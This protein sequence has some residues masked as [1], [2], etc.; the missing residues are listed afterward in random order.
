MYKA[1]RAGSYRSHSERGIPMIRKAAA[2]KVFPGCHEE[3]RKRHDELWPEM[4]EML[5]QHGMITYSIFLEEATDTLFAYLEIA[6]E[7]LW[8]KTADTAICRKWWDYMKDIMETR[9]DHSPVSRE[10]KEVFFL[11]Q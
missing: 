3:Y 11:H 7:A 1:G 10:L 6:D 8:A 5:I 9:E 4:K 2:M